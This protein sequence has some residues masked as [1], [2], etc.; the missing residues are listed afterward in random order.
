[1]AKLGVL[2]EQDFGYYEG[3]PFYARPREGTKSGKDDH[4]SRHQ[5]DPDF[6]DVESKESMTRRMEQF[7]QEHLVPLLKNGDIGEGAAVAIVSH[8]IILSYLWRSFLKRFP[9][10]SV[11][12]SPGLSGGAGGVTHLEYLGGWSN[13]GYLELEVLKIDRVQENELHPTSEDPP[14]MTPEN[15]ELGPIQLLNHRIIIKAV[16]GKEHLVGLK[17]V[18]GVG[19]SQYDEGQKKIEN[20]FKKR[21]M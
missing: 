2:R 18:K 8:G 17:R 11:T 4:R 6:Q 9:K 5:D 15:I 19:S 21:K 10:N 14:S 20:F 1:M 16:N 3:R 13:T 7:L 12:I